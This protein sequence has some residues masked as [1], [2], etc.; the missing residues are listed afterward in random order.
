MIGSGLK[1]FAQAN[2]LSVDSGIGYGVLRN[3]QVTL[4]E[5]SG[6]KQII[7]KTKFPDV[8]KLNA[9]QA[10]LNSV[11]LQ[12]EFRVQQLSFA[13]DGVVI[14]FLD[15]PGTMAKIEAFTDWF[16][17]L[18]AQSGAY[19]AYICPECGEAIENNGTWAMV[20]GVAGYYHPA[21]AEKLSQALYAENEAREQADTGTYASG[22]VGAAI[23]ALLGAVVW[24]LVMSAGYVMS[25][26]GLLIAFLADKGYDL[27]KGRQ[28]KG[29]IVTLIVSVILGVGAG[30]LLSVVF[31]IMGEMM[32]GN[33]PGFT[34]G[35][36]PFFFGA[37]L[38]DEA[39]V[40]DLLVNFAQG[41]LFA[42]IGVFYF[43][44]QAAKKVTAPKM[45][46]LK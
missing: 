12:K 34:Y 7:V 33:L 41:L 35:D 13:T 39:F 44:S 31:I 4:S 19:S 6:F 46:K 10:T 26:I 36:I 20:S 11:N 40:G 2:G 30:T 3:F 15:N 21:C 1:K 14:V 5:G 17:P 42:G 8:E 38:A 22:I 24:A 28:G 18:L 23:G 25:I 9:L 29:K 16:F 37:L 32:Q 45:V 43:L 27:L